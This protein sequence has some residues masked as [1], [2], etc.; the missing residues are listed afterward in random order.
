MKG[1]SNDLHLFVEQEHLLT[2]GHTVG[3]HLSRLPG[4]HMGIGCVWSQ[5]Q[6][7]S[8]FG[9]PREAVALQAFQ[10]GTNYG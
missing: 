2:T 5:P 9:E 1:L 8:A 4:K 7:L 3:L 10:S 6:L